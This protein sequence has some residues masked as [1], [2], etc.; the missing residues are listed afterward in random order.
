MKYLILTYLTILFNVSSSSAQF[1]YSP[2]SI[3]ISQTLTAINKE[4]KENSSSHDN[5]HTIVKFGTDGYIY[6]QYMS[7]DK[8]RMTSS[9][10]IHHADI[11]KVVLDDTYGSV[12]I[13]LICKYKQ[14]CASVRNQLG[15]EHTKHQRSSD[16]ISLVAA[17]TRSGK[18]LVSNIVS[19]I[20]D[21]YGIQISSTTKQEINHF[22]AYFAYYCTGIY[23]KSMHSHMDCRG[24]SNCSGQILRTS[25]EELR[26]SGMQYCRICWD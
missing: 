22:S 6:F 4:L 19:A 9:E 10:R 24:L 16:N 23:S 20:R 17:D 12:S 1:F 2:D 15:E 14:N 8:K 5:S 18:F 26:N 13:K 25:Q 21:I 7:N 11:S 3:F